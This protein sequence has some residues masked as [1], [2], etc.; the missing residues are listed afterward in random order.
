MKLNSNNNI[1]QLAE[2]IDKWQEQL[3]RYAFY[4]VGNRSDAEDVV[5]DAFL[6]IASTTT[7]ISNPKAYLFRI[8]S[9]GCVDM[10]R[11]KSTLAPLEEKMTSPAYSNEMEAEEEFRRIERLLSLLPESQ[12]EVIRLHIHAGLKFTE[13]AEM[14]EEPATTIKSRFASG[15]EKLKQRFIN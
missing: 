15:I 4:R 3:F 12:T 10:I 6:K 8:V 14:L 13:I 9:N 7:P 11:R 5:Q 1:E 2:W